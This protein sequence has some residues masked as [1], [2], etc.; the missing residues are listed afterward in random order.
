MPLVQKAFILKRAQEC[1]QATWDDPEPDHDRL[2][3]PRPGCGRRRRPQRRG[4]GGAVRDQAGGVVRCV[5]LARSAAILAVVVASLV[6][7]SSSAASLPRAPPGR[8]ADRRLR[9]RPRVIGVTGDGTG[10][11]GGFTGRASMR[12]PSRV[13][14]WWAGRIRWSR[15]TRSDARGRGAIWLDNGRPD[16]A[17][18]T[19]HPHVMTVRLW[20]PRRGV[21]TRMRIR[22]RYRGRT[23]VEG[24][25]AVHSPA[26]AFSPAFWLW[27][28]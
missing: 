27:W 2:L 11:L 24:L 12:R 21:F 19:F 15:W 13:N 23:Q 9:I 17:L 18:G 4:E 6:C 1:D 22:F 8:M 25:H 14:L 26:T 16:D 20:R 7:S 5:G 10:F 3:R 28:P